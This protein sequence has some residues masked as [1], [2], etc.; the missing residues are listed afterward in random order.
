[1]GCGDDLGERNNNQMVNETDAKFS[2]FVF[3]VGFVGLEVPTER[4]KKYNI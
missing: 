2:R 3:Y 1:L 4:R